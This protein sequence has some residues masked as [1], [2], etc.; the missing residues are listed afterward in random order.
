MKFKRLLTCIVA[1]GIIV[2]CFSAMMVS[3]APGKLTK[4]NEDFV[5]IPEQQAT[6][7]VSLISKANDADET[8]ITTNEENQ[9]TITFPAGTATDGV[10]ARTATSVNVDM[11]S[12]NESRYS[13]VSFDLT[14]SDL[15]DLVASL[16]DS[17]ATDN[18]RP[19]S[20][21]L[22]DNGYMGGMAHAQKTNYI[23][24]AE[25]KTTALKKAMAG[26]FYNNKYTTDYAVN[27]KHNVK[28]V[29]DLYTNQ[30]WVYIDG[31][32]RGEVKYATPS[33][34][35][36]NLWKRNLV[37]THYATKDVPQSITLENIEVGTCDEVGYQPCLKVGTNDPTVYWFPATTIADRV[38]IRLTMPAGNDKYSIIP[39][40]GSA[41]GMMGWCGSFGICHTWNHADT[42]ATETYS[43]VNG[44]KNV[45]CW[46]KDDE[47]EVVVTFDLDSANKILRVFT[48]NGGYFEYHYTGTTPRNVKINCEM[49]TTGEGEEAVT[50]Y[51]ALPTS[52]E[53]GVV[54]PIGLYVSN[55]HCDVV[56]SFDDTTEG[57]VSVAAFGQTQ[58]DRS[59]IALYSWYDE[60]D[61]CIAAN[62]IKVNVN[63][64]GLYYISGKNT[65]GTTVPEGAAKMK[66][67]LWD[68]SNL[69]PIWESKTIEKVVS[70]N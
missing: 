4:A 59:L 54:L 37:I 55:D 42:I 19:L 44:W 23:E 43:A 49:T 27:D 47:T 51:H 14:A 65:F 20:L 35:T 61:R 10:V 34:V 66:A 53:H 40:T 12:V 32:M 30:V 16:D 50:T 25:T 57:R 8:V 56:E 39:N 15:M 11:S 60:T 29:H 48:N 70:E 38:F 68:K 3:A 45:S 28:M 18:A 41:Y 69:T 9:V 17:A 58:K 52:V 46:E 21:Y 62:M 5:Y 31:V 13:Y 36:Y 6:E 63:K 24:G 26:W 1:L 64:D 67:F 7:A 2:S 33:A 22:A